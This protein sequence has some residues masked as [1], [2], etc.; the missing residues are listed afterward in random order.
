MTIDRISR[1]FSS[2]IKIEFGK[3]TTVKIKIGD[4]YFIKIK[5]G[6]LK[7]LTYCIVQYK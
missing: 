1:H 2:F 5:S 3:I 7:V 6:K 4:F